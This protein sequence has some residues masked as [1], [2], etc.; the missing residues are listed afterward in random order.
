M[1]WFWILFLAIV[2]CLYYFHYVCHVPKIGYKN[3][4]ENKALHQ[5]LAEYVDH[6]FKPL[7]WTWGNT[8]IQTIV[9]VTLRHAPEVKYRRQL[10]QLRDGGQTALDWALSSNDPKTSPFGK[11]SLFFLSPPFFLSSSFNS[12][13]HDWLHGKQRRAGD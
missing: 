10:V 2:A 9:N 12:L 4:S 7:L 3:T 13:P 1:W 8:H 6:K 5:T 11:R